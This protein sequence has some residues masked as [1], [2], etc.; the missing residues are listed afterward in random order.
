MDPELKELIEKLKAAIADQKKTETAINEIKA[1]GADKGRLKDA[2]DAIKQ[3]ETW[4]KELV[5]DVTKRLEAA[6]QMAFD[7]NGNYRGHFGS[8]TEARTFALVVL[9]RTADPDWRKRSVEILNTDHKSFMDRNKD[10]TGEQSLI[11]QEHSTRIHRLVEDSSIFAQRAFPMPMGSS[12]LNF[13][14][15]VSGFR[16]RKSK[17]RTAATRQDM[18]VAPIN[19]TAA[20]YEILTSYPKEIEADALVSIAELIILEIALGF[21]LALEEDGLIGDGS[22]AYDNIAGITFLLQQINGVNDGGGI[23]LG[24][25]GSV[26]GGWATIGKDDILNAIGAVRN[27]RPGQIRAACSNEFYWQ[28]MAKLITDAGGV[29]KMEMQ[30]GF[31]LSVF[32]VPCD[33]SHVMPRTSGNSQIPLL[34][35]DIGQSSTLGRRQALQIE[36]SHEALFTSR[37]VAVLA[38]GRYAINNHNLGTDTTPGPVVGVMTKAAS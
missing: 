7:R 32:G 34:V 23:V 37:E 15:R 19:L 14:R 27:A 4:K 9:A 36:S 28:R 5:A 6:Q 20:N 16:A 26:G 33:I 13:T 12:E 1:W 17:L 31:T 29:T 22:D 38:T 11:P 30:E 2:E 18:A 10:I 3:I 21:S 8:E 35:G 25:S 24:T